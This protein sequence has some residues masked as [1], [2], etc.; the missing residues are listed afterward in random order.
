MPPQSRP[1]PWS[2]AEELY[3]KGKKTK[4]REVLE[5]LFSQGDYRC[6]A[7]FYLWVLYGEAQ[8]YLTS[9]EDYQCLESLP[10]EIALLKRYQ[11]VRQRLTDCQKEREK[12]R[13][14]ISSLK[15]EKVSLKEEIKRLRFELE[16]LEEIRRDT[17][18]RRLKTSH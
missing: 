9:L 15:K 4:A 17:E 7:A 2:V 10:A 14:L 3:L 16:K 11:K 18:Q 5:E 12:D 8:K 13:R 1:D 6:R